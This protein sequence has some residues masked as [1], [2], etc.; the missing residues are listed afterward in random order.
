MKKA[1]FL[2]YFLVLS[3]S[4]SAQQH[5]SFKNIPIEGSATAFCQ[6]LKSKGFKQTGHDKNVFIFRGDFTGQDVNV[7]VGTSGNRKNILSVEVTF[8]PS[9]EWNTLL[10]TYNHYK[11]LYT[12]KYGEPVTC[13]E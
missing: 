4:A 5:L 11:D 13:H 3:L 10:N 7:T 12:T 6:K 9:E 1:L 8:D 2:F